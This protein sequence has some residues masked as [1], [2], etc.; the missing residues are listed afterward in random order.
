MAKLDIDN[1]KLSRIPRPEENEKN[2]SKLNKKWKN[3]KLT[4]IVTWL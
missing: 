1:F 4:D 3:E 2:N